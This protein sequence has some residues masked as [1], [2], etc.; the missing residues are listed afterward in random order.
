MS[1]LTRRNI[2]QPRTE[3]L[4]IPGRRLRRAANGVCRFCL[5]VRRNRHGRAKS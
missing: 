5:I 2:Y 1:T 4:F 3:P